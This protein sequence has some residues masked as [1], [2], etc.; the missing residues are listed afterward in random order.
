M[1]GPLARYALGVTAAALVAAGPPAHAQPPDALYTNGKIVTVDDQFRI[2]EAIATR[3]NR[4]VAVGR[5]ADLAALA[6]TST[7]TIDLGGRTV[8]PGLIDNHMHLLRA[9]LTWLEEVRL[10]GVETRREAI[11]RL[12]ERAAAIPA[13][14]WVY[15]LGGWTREQFA[16]D[17]SPFTREELD[18]AVPDH[19]VL[20]QAAYYRIYL[21]SLAL[22][23]FGIDTDGRGEPWVVRDSSGRPTGEIGEAGVRPISDRLPAP[24]RA[25]IEAGTQKMLQDLNRAGVT[26]VGSAGCPAELLEMYRNWADAGRLDLRVFCIDGPRAETPA[27]TERYLPEIAQIKLYQGDNFIDHVTLGESLYGPLHDPMFLTQPSPA[28]ADLEQWR[29]LAREIARVGKPLHVHANFDVTVSGFLDQLEAINAEYPLHNLR[30]VFA[31]A[32]QL[33]STTLAR[34]K[35]LGIYAAVHPWAVINGGINVDVF[36]EAALDMAPLRTIQD[37]GITWGFGSDGSRA[38]Q[39]LPFNILSWA[40]TGKMVG[41]RDVLRQT[42][43]REEALIAFTRN[44]AYIVFREDEIGSIEPGKLA[45]FVVLDRDYL[46]V[47]AAQIKAIEATMTVVDGRIVYD[48]R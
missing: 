10:D 12:R 18:R 8:I 4:I 46:S 33:S 38:V 26:T 19:P 42:L 41:G 5:S 45:D 11:A 2:A 7:R 27:D 24:S 20:L 44:N 48:S 6:G 16:D 1:T 15:T 28:R 31:H 3:G 23:A 17:P 21:N 34:M 36:G 30:W 47:P 14:D 9:G 39:V 25:T 22:A 13:G 43:T 35:A 32:N 40:V 29:R 37:S